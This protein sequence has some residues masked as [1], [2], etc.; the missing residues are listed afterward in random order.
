MKVTKLGHCCLLVEVD[1]KRILT[2]PGGFTADSHVLAG[3]DIVLITHE[4]GDHLHVESLKELVQKNPAVSVYCNGSVGA[5]LSVAGITHTVLEGTD[6]AECEGVVLTAC[7]AP[8]AEIFEQFGAVQNT[9][10]FIAE[11]LFYPGDSY[12]EPGK[13]VEVLALP[14]GGPWCKMTDTLHYALRVKPEHAF[15]VHDGIEREDRV[16][17]HHGLAARI[18]A[19]HHISFKPLLSGDSV[20]Y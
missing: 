17:I 5:L 18:L 16:Q 20:E 3:I 1:G 13:P 19:E 11:R 2:D 14:V 6:S 4:H 8:H 15:P 12:G 10:Y 9:G 7:D